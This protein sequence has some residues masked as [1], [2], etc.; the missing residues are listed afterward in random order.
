MRDHTLESSQAT[1]PAIRHPLRDV[2]PETQ[3]EYL[4]FSLCQGAMRT[5]CKIDNASLYFQVSQQTFPQ[6]GP[7]LL[8]PDMYAKQAV[9]LP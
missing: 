9:I 3:K 4:R 8:R 6:P 7:G 2:T 5:S 1:T